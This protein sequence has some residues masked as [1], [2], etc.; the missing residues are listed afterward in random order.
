[1]SLS[2]TLTSQRSRKQLT[3][4]SS[5]L[6]RQLFASARSLPTL[7]AIITG[8]LLAAC[9][10]RAGSFD[11]QLSFHSISSLKRQSEQAYAPTMSTASAFVRAGQGD[12]KQRY[13]HIDP[14]TGKWRPPLQQGTL[15]WLLCPELTSNNELYRSS[16]LD[17]Q[18]PWQVDQ[19]QEPNQQYA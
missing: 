14:A 6:V 18:R 17:G 1:L 4:P 8:F 10:L 11:E 13:W 3:P 2:R 16:T 7:Q 9:C 5:Q 19:R 15:I 12:H